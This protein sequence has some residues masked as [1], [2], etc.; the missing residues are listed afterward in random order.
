V[1]RRDVIS[2]ADED[3]LTFDV[4]DEALEQAASADRQALTWVYCTHHWY[5]CEWPQ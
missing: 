2:D 1:G 5:Y 3:I 4:P